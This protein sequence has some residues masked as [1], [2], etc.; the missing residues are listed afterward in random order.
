MVLVFLGCNGDN[1]KELFLMLS[2]QTKQ[3]FS[4]ISQCIPDE[5]RPREVGSAPRL[6]LWLALHVTVTCI[7]RHNCNCVHADIES[8]PEP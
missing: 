7:F 5:L 8:F 2:H 3:Q 6:C 4:N 1:F